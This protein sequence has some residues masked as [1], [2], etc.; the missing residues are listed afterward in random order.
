[1]VIIGYR[2]IYS[3]AAKF[4]RTYFQVVPIP[5]FLQAP[6]WALLDRRF[7]DGPREA[8]AESSTPQDGSVKPLPVHKHQAYGI[9]CM[10]WQDFDGAH[11]GEWTAPSKNQ[12]GNATNTCPTSRNKSAQQHPCRCRVCVAVFCLLHGSF[13]SRTWPCARKA[14]EMRRISAGNTQQMHCNFLGVAV[15]FCV[16]WPK[17][18]RKADACVFPVKVRP[19]SSISVRENRVSGPEAPLRNIT[20]MRCGAKRNPASPSLGSLGLSPWEWVWSTESQRLRPRLGI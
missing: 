15:Q 12:S 1:M 16:G 8:L 3:G 5:C 6:I 2:I 9:M 19:N 20:H 7:F 11:V 4:D 14:Q 13:V 17:A 10:G 18:G